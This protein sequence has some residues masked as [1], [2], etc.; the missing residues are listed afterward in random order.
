MTDSLQFNC[1]VEGDPLSRAFPFK[2]SSN[3]LVGTFKTAL[4]QSTEC[5]QA[6]DGVDSKDLQ[7][8][9]VSIPFKDFPLETVF[10]L[11]S[12]DEK[13]ELYSV[14]RLNPG[15]ASNDQLRII[16]QRPSKGSIAF[17]LCLPV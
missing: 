13:E 8:W 15:Y 9:L 7:L 4:S 11:K 17:I 5:S 12:L 2:A 14:D 3:E 10:E 6:L 1:L 16:I